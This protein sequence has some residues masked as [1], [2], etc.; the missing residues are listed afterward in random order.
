MATVPNTSITP[1]TWNGVYPLSDLPTGDYWKGSY[2]NAY[3]CVGFARMVLD[4]TYGAGTAI[5]GSSVFSSTATT[6]LQNLFNSIYVGDRVT[7]QKRGLTGAN[8]QHA[9]I[10]AG[11][12]S[13]GITVYDC[14]YTG[15][16]KIGYYTVTWSTLCSRYDKIRSGVHHA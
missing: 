4:A 9:I 12:S 2:A 13:T 15:A 10:V 3:T 14:N 8:D 1:S 16:D 6:T 5:S 11:K 7:F